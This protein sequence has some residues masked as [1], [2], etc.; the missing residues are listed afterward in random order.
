MCNRFS[1]AADLDEVRDH[2][3]IQRVMYYYKNRYNISPTQ[4]T[5][6]ILHQDGERVLDE[7]RWGFIPFWGRDAVNANLM[8]VHENP[9]YYKLVETKRCVIPSNGLYYWRQEGKKS[10]A[11]RVVMPDRGL[12][13]IAGLYEVWRDTRKEPLRT[14]TMLMTGANMVTREFGSK[15]PAILSEE[16][17]NTWLDPANTRVTQLL[18]LLKS[19]NST[20]MNLYPVTPMVANDE[21]DCYECVEEMD[22]KLAYVRSF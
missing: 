2:F 17:I 22:Q 12:F 5:P 9:S 10:Y 14:C 4:H 16:E 15:M 8:T 1:L 18:P 19:Y 20:E 11:V 6:I 7:F 13:G 21:H 3:K